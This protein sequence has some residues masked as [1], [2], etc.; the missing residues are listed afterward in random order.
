[1]SYVISSGSPLLAAK[2]LREQDLLM[3]TEL[4]LP[5]SFVAC[6]FLAINV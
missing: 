4:H 1:M 6:E 2:L 3:L 5:I